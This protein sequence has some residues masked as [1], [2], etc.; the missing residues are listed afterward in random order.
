M[1]PLIGMTS[2]RHNDSYQFPGPWPRGAVLSDDYAQGVEA[3]GGVPFMIP[4]VTEPETLREYAARMDGLLLTGGDDVDPAV[5]GEEPRIG[6]GQVTAERDELEATL[7]SELIALGKPILGICRGMQILNA[8]FGGTLYQDLPREWKG[9]IQHSQRAR[10]NHLS[11][12]LTIE[13]GCRVYDLMGGNTQQRSNSYHHQ[14]VQNVGRDLVAV[15]WD[16]EGLVEA[17]EHINHP[18]L[19]AVQWHPENLWR[20]APEHLGLFRGLVQAAT[21]R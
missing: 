5:Y 14:A 12:T 18:F 4:Y 20:T 15:A 9:S 10:R 7:I 11:H 2:Y 16:E 13:P 8:F 6:L 17:M 21:H 3:A 1:K 19:V